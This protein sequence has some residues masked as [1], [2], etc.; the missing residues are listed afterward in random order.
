MEQNKEQLRKSATGW[1]V[2]ITQI[3][4]T[5]TRHLY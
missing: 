3:S 4:C 5:D 1:W 2:C